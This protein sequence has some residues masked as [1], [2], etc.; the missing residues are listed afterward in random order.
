MTVIQ[1]LIYE[2]EIYEHTKIG[3]TR[4][5]PSAAADRYVKTNIEKKV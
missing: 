3:F 5:N 4:G 2:A 1:N